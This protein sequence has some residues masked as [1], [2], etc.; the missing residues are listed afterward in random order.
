MTRLLRATLS[1]VA[2]A[3][4]LIAGGCTVGPNY[5]RPAL[6][7]PERFRFAEQQAESFADLPWWEVTRDPQLQ[8]LV[9]E[10]IANN[11]DLRAAAAR[12]EQA[13]ARAG[14]ARSFLFPEVGAG[15]GY[16][17]QQ[18]SRLGDPPNESGDRTFQNWSLGFNL[19]WEIDLFGRIRRESESAVAIFLA[20]EQARRG[21]LVT[22]VA[23]VASNYLRLRELDLQLQIS[24]NTVEINDETV[25]FYATR[26]DGGV[27]NRLELD[28]ALANRSRTATSIPRIELQIAQ[29]E[30]LL[31]LLLGRPPGRVERAG[32]LSEADATVAVP[33]GLPAA[34]LERRPDVV[35][36]EQRLVSANADI[37]AA[38]ALFFPT[39]SLT[40]FLGGV[41]RELAD[42]VKSDAFA[43]DV[44][45]GLFQPI[46]Q[47]GRIRRNYE[48][49]QA[50]FEE[51]LALY[52]KAALNGYREVADALVAIQK[53]TEERVELEKGVVALREAASLARSRY[54]TGLSDYLE[55][56]IADQQ[57]F[58]QEVLL[59]KAR[60]A[61]A[62]AIVDLYRALGG[63]W[64]TEAA[65]P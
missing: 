29:T 60:G 52:R 65:A 46:F 40:G 19:A 12:V 4:A 49:A 33:A 37:G 58:D 43:W 22:L 5:T 59:A 25:R 62:R 54:D 18:T 8:A 26:L 31:S 7:T 55:I 21:V 44:S 51:A 17:A 38:K 15:V 56:L 27:S 23:D 20:T 61:E 42:L 57:L 64:Q 36:A 39:I 48:A 53:L 11:L 30:N 13:R 16:T 1:A 28:Q 63:G 24:R 35:E 47:A 32:P 2:I 50:R 6:T 10:A 9:R 41:S 14:I 45:P 3:V 34:L